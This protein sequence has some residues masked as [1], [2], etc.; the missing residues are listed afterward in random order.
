MENRNLTATGLKSQ[1]EGRHQGLAHSPQ[2]GAT[3]LVKPDGT[4]RRYADRWHKS[5]EVGQEQGPVGGGLGNNY[6]HV[7][8]V[9]IK[10]EFTPQGNTAMWP[11]R[12]VDGA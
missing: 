4:M 1:A 11:P 5:A 3:A 2:H 9:N 12:G 7:I 10:Q 6:F 8:F